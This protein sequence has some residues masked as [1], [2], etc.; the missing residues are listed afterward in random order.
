MSLKQGHFSTS[1]DLMFIPTV[2]LFSGVF[3]NIIFTFIANL[4]KC[5]ALII[6]KTNKQKSLHHLRFLFLQADTPFLRR[7]AL[8]N[9]WGC[10]EV[11]EVR[12]QEGKGRREPSAQG[13][14]SQVTQEEKGNSWDG[15]WKFLMK[16]Q[17]LWSE[18]L[19]PGRR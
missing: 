16:D 15:V 9:C 18:G 4:T 5:F 6:K 17:G 13:T 10:E 8:D 3:V 7:R 11:Q 12:S 1:Y 2:S 14:T 19:T